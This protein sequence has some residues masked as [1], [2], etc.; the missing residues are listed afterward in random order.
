MNHDFEYLKSIALDPFGQRLALRARH[1]V[2]DLSTAGAVLDPVTAQQIANGTW[3]EAECC[4]DPG[5]D[6]FP[7]LEAAPT[8]P[9]SH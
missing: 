8:A 4:C 5:P 1:A 3:S 6:D 9:G 7:E 2:D